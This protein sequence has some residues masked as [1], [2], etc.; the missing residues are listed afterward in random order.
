MA[1]GADLLEGIR[2]SPQD[3]KRQELDRVLSH[4]GFRKSEGANHTIYRHEHLPPGYVVIIPRH[5]TV[6]AYV[7]RKVV[8]AVDLVVRKEDSDEK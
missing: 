5:Q 7:A 1:S 3:R 2:R 8:K 4:F 6:R